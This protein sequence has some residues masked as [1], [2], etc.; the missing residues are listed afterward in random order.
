MYKLYRNF[1][2]SSSFQ[3]FR[4]GSTV[5]LI[6]PVSFKSFNFNNFFPISS[7]VFFV[8]SK[9]FLAPVFST[10]ENFFNGFSS[11][12]YK[13]LHAKGIGFKVYYYR[14]RHKLYFMLGY[15]HITAF[16]LSSEVFVRVRKQFVLLIS[17]N[18]QILN[19]T[20]VN[21]RLL[22]YPDPYRGKGIRFR[23]Q[24]M[25]FKVGKQR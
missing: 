23:Y 20:I 5:S 19:N 4:S 6:A 7:E 13:V 14:K 21:V 18:R 17:S 3:I 25:K 12:Y 15:N 9:K 24:I 11:F 10:I 22:R 1:S 8:T 16:Q 2:L